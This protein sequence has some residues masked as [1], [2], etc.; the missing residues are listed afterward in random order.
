ME[1][2]VPKHSFEA[3]KIAINTVVHGFQYSEVTDRIYGASQLCEVDVNCPAGAGFGNE[4]DAV[5]KIFSGTAELC[6]GSLVSNDCQDL[7]SF[8]LTANHCLTSAPIT[9]NWVFRFN[10]DSPNPTAPTCRGSDATTWIT[11]S[12]ANLRANWATT[13]FALV[14]MTG[15]II[16]QPTLAVAGWNR[17]TTVPT[18]IVTAIHHPV[19]DVKKISSDDEPLGTGNPSFW[20]IDQWDNGL[21]EP[22]SSGSPLFDAAHRV[23]GQ[24]QGG[25][26][27][28]GCLNGGSLVDN[29]DYGRFDVS[30]TGG[31]T[32]ATRLS[33]WLGASGTPP[34]TINTIPVPIVSGTDPVCSASS[35]TFTLTDNVP[36]RTATWLVTPSSLFVTASGSGNTASLQASNSSVSGL[37]TLTFTISAGSGC[38]TISVTRQI[39]VGKPDI[40]VMGDDKLCPREPGFAELTYD[41]GDSR[42]QHV[43]NVTWTFTGPLSTFLGYSDFAR[44]RAG[45]SAGYGTITVTV[46]NVCGS[47]SASF[48]Y[49]IDDCGGGKAMALKLSPNPIAGFTNVK[50]TGQGTENIEKFSL[51]VY[52]GL[53]NRVFFKDFHTRE[54]QIDLG[55]L[56]P[57]VYFVEVFAEGISLH[58]RI[59]KTY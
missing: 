5:C 51:N 6:S 42:I 10:Y 11:Y 32:A 58:K 54:E 9:A 49:Q 1:A 34:T 57:G 50:I 25:D 17:A 13:D 4:R 3:F 28:I 36:G 19:G 23:I 8:V 20:R 29:N 21:V 7:R 30:W 43:L 56:K 44:Y 26:N 40:S 45:T 59:L 39:W 33:D 15:S 22:G 18:Q 24:L 38:S 55:M 46:T 41:V 47:T 12:G 48:P 53:G 27:N 35:Q 14:E 16:G 37:A 2:I 52:D 31:G